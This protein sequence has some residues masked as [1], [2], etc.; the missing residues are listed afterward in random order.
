MR[1]AKIVA[2]LGPKTADYPSILRLVREGM[3]VARLNFSHGDHE[4]HRR[5]L[6]HVRRAAAECGRTVAALADLC[7]PKIRLGELP[8]AGV[9][10]PAGTEIVFTG[11]P[12][13]GGAALAISQPNLAREL[14]AGQ[15]LFV[16]DGL[17]E[18]VVIAIRGDDVVC[19]SVNGGTLRSRKGVNVAAGLLSLPALTDKDVLDLAFARDVLKVDYFAL[20]FVRHADDV[21]AA[22]ALAGDIPVIAK[23]EKPQAVAPD[24]LEEIADVADGFM[25]ARGDLGVEMGAEKVPLAQKRIVRI[26]ARHGKPAIVATQMLESMIRNPRPTRAEVSDVANAILDGADAVMLSAETA[27]GDYPFEAVATMRRIIEEVEENAL[28]NDRQKLEPPE[29][30]GVEYAAAHAAA[31]TAEAAVVP[32]VAVCSASGRSVALVS[33][34]RPPARILGVAKTP[35]VARRMALLWG[36]EPILGLPLDDEA[37]TLAA[38]KV[39]IAR[40]KMAEPGQLIAVAFGKDISQ[41]AGSTTMKLLPMTKD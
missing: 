37:S 28:P 36:V 41:P 38:L 30:F 1:K 6:E 35:E 34:H 32:V 39:E 3:D 10:A 11:R 2:T 18:F 25:V 5:T 31:R 22:K 13:P 23:I 20:S 21:R 19:R 14:A 16:E 12:R 15:K 29:N 40:R 4:G 9:P 7:G 17:L 26:A 8:E 27:A 33:A 24:R